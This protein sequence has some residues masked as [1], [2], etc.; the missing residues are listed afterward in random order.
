MIFFVL[1]LITKNTVIGHLRCCDHH[2]PTIPSFRAFLP[3]QNRPDVVSYNV[4]L[5]AL[6]LGSLIPRSIKASMEDE[7]VD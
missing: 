7:G 1:L 6:G 4:L 3:R 2:H 5:Q